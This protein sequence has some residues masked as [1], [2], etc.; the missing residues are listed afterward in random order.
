M[1]NKINKVSK[2]ANVVLMAIILM[3]S[4]CNNK[5]ENSDAGKK[6][7]EPPAMDIHTA[8]LLGD[9]DVI[10]LHIE[11][12]T[13]I[14]KKDEVM[15]SSP[16]ITA[17]VL[18]RKEVVKVLIDAGADVNL[19]NNE[20]STAL[21]TASFLCRTEIVEMLLKN[22]ADK[23]LKNIYGSTAME[24]VAGPFSDVKHIY[25]QFARDLGPIGLK[26]DYK[27]LQE[28]RPVIAELLK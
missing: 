25:D 6:M 24:S 18:D 27:R 2:K 3:I 12:G 16:L 15:G 4:A 28:T 5:D 26:L 9:L 13:D 22:G 14:N 1:K 10:I 11:A 23:N 20:G 7:T 21:H 19:Q 8:A 17:T